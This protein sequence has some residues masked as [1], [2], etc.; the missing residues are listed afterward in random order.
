ML[1]EH[2][3][4]ELVMQRESDGKF[5]LG[6]IADI[7]EQ[8]HDYFNHLLYKVDWFYEARIEWWKYKAQDI[9]EFKEVL[10]EQINGTTAGTQNR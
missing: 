10:K 7:V 2:K 1:N 5:T 3:I 8:S 9:T 4:G 6:Y